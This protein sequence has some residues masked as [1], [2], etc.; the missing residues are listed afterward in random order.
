MSQR[1]LLSILCAWTAFACVP[2]TDDLNPA[3]AAGFALVPSAATR[4]EPF[5][6]E[7]GYVVTIDAVVILL[8]LFAYPRRD[9]PY[10][11]E[12]LQGGNDT[13]LISG[14]RTEPLYLPGVSTGETTLNV[15]FS[16][17]FLGADSIL[18]PVTDDAVREYLPRFEQPADLILEFGEPRPSPPPFGPSMLISLHAVGN[19]RTYRSSFTLDVDSVTTN[20][21]PSM[22]VT[23]NSLQTAPLDVRAEL[24]F[25]DVD[26]CGNRCS[27]GYGE[28][29]AG[30]PY[31]DEAL[32]SLPPVFG[33]FALADADGDGIIT[34]AELRDSS[35]DDGTF[36]ATLQRRAGRIF[37]RS[38]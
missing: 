37:A 35:R 1:H 28:D 32:A 20:V 22:L 10:S 15:S 23:A 9:Y 12:G 34:G 36:P 3:G 7:D 26:T 33:P 18:E 17:L 16:Q 13:V 6:T 24:L 30:P 11:A 29:H 31:S 2:S 27:A 21:G 25:M 4:G 19:G 5:S 38:E 8:D 14:K